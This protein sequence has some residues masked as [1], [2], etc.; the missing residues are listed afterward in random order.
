[1]GHHRAEL[2]G[3]LK[4]ANNRYWRDAEGPEVRSSLKLGCSTYKLGDL[5]QREKLS[6]EFLER[7]NERIHG[8][9]LLA[10]CWP[11]SKPYKCLPVYH[12]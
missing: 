5:G 3:G 9:C 2:G 6:L 10:Q 11:H 7:L 1:M 12:Y 4:S 8:K